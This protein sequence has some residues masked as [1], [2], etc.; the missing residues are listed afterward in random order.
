MNDAIRFGG[1]T[2]TVDTAMVCECDHGTCWN[3][4]GDPDHYE[5]CPCPKMEGKFSLAAAPDEDCVEWESVHW[6]Y[7]AKAELLQ[8][9]TDLRELVESLP[10]P[11]QR[12]TH[13]PPMAS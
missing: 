10:E 12:T 13:G 2:L 1:F 9:L 8:R 4:E 5:Q 6:G 3:R 11:E 7:L